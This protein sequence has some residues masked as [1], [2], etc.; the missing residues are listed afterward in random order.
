VLSTDFFGHDATAR[1][2]LDDPDRREIVARAAGTGEEATVTES[3]AAP[4]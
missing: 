1:I 3:L 4:I 2:V